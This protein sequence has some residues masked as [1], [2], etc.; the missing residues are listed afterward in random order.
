MNKDSVLYYAAAGI[1]AAVYIARRTA[2]EPRGQELQITWLTAITCLAL[3]H[4]R[5]KLHKLTQS[6]FSRGQNIQDEENDSDDDI[7]D[8]KPYVPIAFFMLLISSLQS[9]P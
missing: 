1:P 7:P 9:G 4:H 3:V 8:L 2:L 6:F 5:S